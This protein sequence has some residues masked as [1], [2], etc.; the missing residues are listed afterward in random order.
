MTFLK[1]ILIILLVYFALKF[2]IKLLTPYII[3]YL[4]KKVGQ[5]F[6]QSFGGSPFQ[7]QS[8]TKEGDVT[9]DKRTSNT[10]KPN[11]KIGEYVDF[12]EID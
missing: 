2:L 3:R 5:K 7:P 12:E 10:T 1:T 6:E 11:T 9:I 8:N 4:S